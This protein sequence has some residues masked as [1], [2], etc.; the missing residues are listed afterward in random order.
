MRTTT[1][2]TSDPSRPLPAPS[3]VAIVAI[4]NELL[5]G[6]VRDANV[7]YLAGELYGLGLSLDLVLIC[8]DEPAAIVDAV[9]LARARADLVLTTGGVGPTHDDVTLAAI[10]Q[11]FGR[12]RVR[13]AR[14][15]AD[16]RAHWRGAINEDVL[17]MA[18]V[19]EGAELIRPV[20][21][22]LPIIRVE[23][24]HVLPGEPTAL[25]LMFEPWKETLRQRPYVL[26]R[27][28]LDVDEGELSPHL[29]A[30]QAD[31]PT[32]QIGSYPRFDAGAPYRVLVT[33]EGKDPTA[34][35]AASDGL[36]RRLRDVF[37][38]PALLSVDAP[39]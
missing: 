4:G 26:S 27:V 11:A 1:T 12:G 17:A 20:P 9:G 22:F 33:L 10:A 23:N 8:K 3:R 2:T 36:V 28:T 34:V 6:K 21:F 39:G 5:S 18:D 13:D 24:V 37:G 25:R 19:P 38:A 7:H 30:H 14:L 31:H 32:T 16:L 29:R 15:E 35:R